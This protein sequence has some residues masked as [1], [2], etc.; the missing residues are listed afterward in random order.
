MLLYLTRRQ[1][2]RDNSTDNI[3]TT[4]K[5]EKQQQQ[6]NNNHNKNNNSKYM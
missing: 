2:Q 5:G 4:L 1:L 6:N 3:Y